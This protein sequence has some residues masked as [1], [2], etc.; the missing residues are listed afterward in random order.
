MSHFISI[1]E[2]ERDKIEVK[3]RDESYS[4]YFK[5]VAEIKN[6]KQMRRLM[7]DL[8]RKGVEFRSSWLD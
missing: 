2:R 1:R 6:P 3:L 8:R 4:V 5:G 7:E